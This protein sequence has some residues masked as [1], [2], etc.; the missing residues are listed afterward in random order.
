MKVLG[1]DSQKTSYWAIPPGDHEVGEER[2]E[3]HGAPSPV[4]VF[5]TETPTGHG[6]NFVVVKPVNKQEVSEDVD[7]GKD[8]VEQEK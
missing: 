7:S 4:V 5:V 3:H 6:A 1:T 2:E 8:N